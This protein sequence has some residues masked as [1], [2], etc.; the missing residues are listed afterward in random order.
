MH[1]PSSSERAAKWV[2]H[3]LG[4]RYEGQVG[5]LP[6]YYLVSVPA[7]GD[8]F[9]KRRD[10]DENDLLMAAFKSQKQKHHASMSRRDSGHVYWDLVLRIERLAARKRVK[11][12]LPLTLRGADGTILL[13]DTEN[14]LGIRDPGFD[15]Q[16]HL[17]NQ[18]TRGHDINVTGVWRQGITGKG[19]TVAI[20]DDGLDY[21]NRDLESNFYAAGSYDFNDHVS[22]PKPKLSDDTHGTR[23][24]GQIAASKNDLCGIGIAYGAKVA[25]IRI[26]SGEIT[27]ADEAAALNYKF[28]E[29]DIYSCS[30]GPP[31]DGQAME[32]PRGIL[33]DAF[34]NGITNG[35]GGKGSIFVFA[36]GNGAPFGDNCNFD[37]YTNSIYTITI[38]AIDHLD[39]HPYYSETCSAQMV[40]TTDVGKDAC[41]ESHGGTSAAAPT[42]AGIFALVLSVRP[43]LTW[44]DLQHLCV[45]TAVPVHVEDSD[46]KLL[47]SQR[48]YSHKF[49]YGKLDAYAIVEAAK[50]HQLVN[51]QTMI[52]ALAF[53][54]QTTGGKDIPDSSGLKERRALNTTI[55]I[56][57]DMVRQ[58]NLKQLEHVVVTVNIEHERRGD[59]VITLRSPH[60]VESE[61]ATQRPL[62][63]SKDGIRDWKFM[64]VKHWQEDPIGDWTLLV[65]DVSHPEARGKMLNWTLTL[66]GEAG[67]AQKVTLKSQL[68][69]EALS[70]PEPIPSRPTRIR[71]K[72]TSSSSGLATAT[73][74]ASASAAISEKAKTA[75]YRPLNGA[76]GLWIHKR[77]RQVQWWLEQEKEEHSMSFVFSVG[78]LSDEFMSDDEN[79]QQQQ[80]QQQQQ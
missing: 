47:P 55:R 2:A 3:E 8:G 29:N 65:Y 16:W 21:D 22:L 54:E 63:E 12:V 15:K 56:T 13:N 28:Q 45:Q 49:G 17:V 18:G 37:G 30:W 32:G 53:S 23:C 78:D 38:G 77:R 60:Q 59:L 73:A 80:Q 39:Q 24:A 52:H 74:S 70:M 68:R 33:A 42:A 11:R 19:S 5:E 75:E 1:V 14:M 4:A 51:E 48:L 66:Y 7:G 69:S 61:L 43:D 41:S 76:V 27:D 46:W 67:D 79:E 26:L 10:T 58:A 62:D 25:G 34:I 9:A 44:R 71:A 20:L 31:D 64:S 50:T 35:R 36:T 40:Y 72:H 6:T 57:P